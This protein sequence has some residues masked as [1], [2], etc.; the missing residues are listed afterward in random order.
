MTHS[1]SSSVWRK[2]A[3]YSEARRSARCPVEQQRKS[4]E[5]MPWAITSPYLLLELLLLVLDLHD[6]LG[7]CLR[8]CN[9]ASPKS[10]ASIG[11]RGNRRLIGRCHDEQWL[12]TCLEVEERMAVVTSEGSGVDPGREAARRVKRG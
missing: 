6:L 5:R 1:H 9:I 11:A 8:S 4:I 3:S 10:I 2:E 7:W 12:T